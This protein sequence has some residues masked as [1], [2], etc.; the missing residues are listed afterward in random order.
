MRYISKDILRYF[1]SY[2][3]IYLKVIVIYAE[4]TAKKPKPKARSTSEGTEMENSNL[5]KRSGR[6]SE[7]SEVI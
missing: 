1:E 4:E 7:T 3:E 5:K 2:I 6:C